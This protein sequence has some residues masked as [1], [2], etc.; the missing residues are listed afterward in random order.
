M[1][2]GDLVRTKGLSYCDEVVAALALSVD[3][4]YGIVSQVSL[5][6]DRSWAF[7]SFVKKDGSITNHKVY[8]EYLNVISEIIS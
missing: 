1:K 4:C 5:D 3:D 2:I 7:V 8:S 6:A